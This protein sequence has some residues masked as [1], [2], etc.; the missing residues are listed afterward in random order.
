ML[1]EAVHSGAVGAIE[2]MLNAALAYDP[3]SRDRLAG[4]DGKVILLKSDFPPLSIAVEPRVDQIL[5]HAHWQDEAD[6]NLSGSL[7]ALV[8]LIATGQGR[9]SLSGTGVRATG[10]MELLT[11]CN[12]VAQNLDVDWE[13]M[14]ARLVGDV[15]AHLLGEAIRKAIA[16]QKETDARARSALGE[17]AQEELRLN[18]T[19]TEFGEFCAAV[20][21]LSADTDRLAVRV[22]QLA[23][24]LQ[25]GSTGD[26]Q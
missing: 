17:L 1:L 6:L 25:D 5:L 11:H 21:K 7:P 2:K 4:L 24:R 12:K 13:A 15:P 23:S 8:A 19:T 3:V 22:Q 16:V 9:S 14:L 26:S 10:D 18:P 20:R